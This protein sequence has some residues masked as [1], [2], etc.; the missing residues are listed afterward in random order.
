MQGAAGSHIS[1]LQNAVGRF[2]SP[3]QHASARFDSPLHN[4]A[5]RFDCSGE[6]NFNCNN[7]TNL[8]PNLK[9][10]LRYESRSKVGTFDGKNGGGKSRATVPLKPIYLCNKN[11][12][13]DLT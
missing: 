7:S 5:E 11:N 12:E 6:S 3:L 4:A 8:K 2:D 9:K 1:P 10:N 13:L